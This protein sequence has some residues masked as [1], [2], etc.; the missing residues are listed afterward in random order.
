MSV[1]TRCF[2]VALGFLFVAHP[3]AADAQA[4]DPPIDRQKLIALARTHL[5]KRSDQS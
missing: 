2:A 1:S 3:I 4:K 5:P